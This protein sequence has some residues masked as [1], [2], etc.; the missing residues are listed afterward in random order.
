MESL[1]SRCVDS[2]RYNTERASQ[3]VRGILPNVPESFP[4][5]DAVESDFRRIGG[6]RATERVGVSKTRDNCKNSTPYKTHGATRQ[7]LSR[8][9]RQINSALIELKE[10]PILPCLILKSLCFQP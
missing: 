2:L 8:Q 7:R 5:C 10:S 3:N 9:R 6:S 1:Y 4:N